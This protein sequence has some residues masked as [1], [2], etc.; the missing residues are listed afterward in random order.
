M[1]RAA[2]IVALTFL[3]VWALALTT[4]AFAQGV[5]E[6]KVEN[7]HSP[8][9]CTPGSE[10]GSDEQRDHLLRRLAWSSQGLASSTTTRRASL[11][12]RTRSTPRTYF[13]AAAITAQ[14]LFIRGT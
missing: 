4:L 6:R 1:K 14:I 8:H 7:G 5:P 11:K 2:L 12:E 3:L 13:F 9:Y 10:A